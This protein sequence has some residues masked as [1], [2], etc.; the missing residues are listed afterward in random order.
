MCLG[1][2]GF[3]PVILVGGTGPNIRILE[4][5]ACVRCNRLR[6]SFS[7]TKPIFVNTRW[8]TILKEYATPLRIWASSKRDRSAPGLCPPVGSQGRQRAIETILPRSPTFA[9]CNP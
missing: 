7:G 4:S 3:E 8:E 6:L 9:F 1:R 2:M 5:R